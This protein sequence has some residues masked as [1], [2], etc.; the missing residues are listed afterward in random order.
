M[1]GGVAAGVEPG[2]GTAAGAAA[3]AVAE[4]GDGVA[5]TVQAWGAGIGAGAVEVT[6]GA[7]AWAGPPFACC[8]I[9]PASHRAAA[10]TPI[11]LMAAELSGRI[12]HS[13]PVDVAERPTLADPLSC[14]RSS[15]ADAPLITSSA[16]G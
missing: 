16:G 14:Q 10:S 15:P 11:P 8:Q 13:P 1:A 7:A 6:T 2:F 5:V 12:P 9:G 4:A 3:P